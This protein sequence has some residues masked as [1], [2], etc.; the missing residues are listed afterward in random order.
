MK[1]PGTTETRKLGMPIATSL[2]VGNVIGSGVFL[3]PA[4]LGSYGGICIVGWLF[5]SAGGVLLAVVF[6]RLS[7]MMPAA[8]GPYAYTREGFGRFAGYLIAWGYWIGLW[9]G[10]AA[11]A[12]ALVSYLGVFWPALARTPALG[13]T[14]C[15]AMIWLLAAVNIAGVR[16]AGILSLVT[17]IL[18]VIPLLAIGIFGLAY[19][20]PGHFTP[21]NR[22]GLSIPAAV[23]ASA[24]LTLW[25][26]LGL[27]S[28][29]VPANDVRDPRKTIPRA[30]IL[31]TAVSAVIY[32]LATVSVMGIVPPEKLVSSNA[33]FSDAAR[34]MWG[35]WAGYLI[36]GGAV[37]SCFGALNGWTLLVSQVPL[38]SA[39]DGLFPSI[40]ARV[41]RRGTPVAGIVISDVLISVLVILNFTK[42]LVGMFTFIILLATLTTL[43]PY[44]FCSVAELLMLMKD[45]R[46]APRRLPRK[47]IAISIPTFVYALWAIG[48]SGRDA[49]FWGI[50]LILAG[51]PF[52]VWIRWREVKRQLPQDTQ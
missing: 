10:N 47:L 30:T 26:F 25:A 24:A 21:F 27:E 11:I 29:T 5:T 9:T 43:F 7:R 44:V 52:Y 1:A 20:E 3:L 6:S 40:F 42:G 36:A 39:R 33:P 32:I 18:K 51:M 28:A 31:G 4:S 37:I 35:G 50:I 41:S 46:N 14:V 12:T 38:A 23:S 17:T 16:K 8:G 48:G 19:L 45:P 13:A 49:V 2:V 34:A 22:S 15:I